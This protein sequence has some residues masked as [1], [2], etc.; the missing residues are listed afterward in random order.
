M[1]ATGLLI[2]AAL[3]VIQSI[4][5]LLRYRISAADNNDMATKTEPMLPKEVLISMIVFTAYVATIEI[6][7]F[8]INSFVLL[9]IL[10]TMFYVKEVK[11]DTTNKKGLVKVF[12]NIVIIATIS[13]FLIQQIFV[14]ILK[15]GLPKG[16]FGI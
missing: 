12:I 16:I 8:L 11:V 1:I 9:I 6:F 13:L 3:L 14:T 2:L 10:M 7:G 4:T 5:K 15:V